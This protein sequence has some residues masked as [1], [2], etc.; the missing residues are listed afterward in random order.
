MSA[1]KLGMCL[2]IACAV[3]VSARMQAAE[4]AV[5][6]KTF[7]TP[8]E[9]V[10]ALVAAAEKFDVTALKE[11]AGPDG[12]DLVVTDDP[13]LDKNQ[14]TA[15]AAQARVKTKIVRDP[16]NP[17]IVTFIVGNEDWPAP[18]RW[19]KK[20]VDGSSIPRRGARKSCTAALEP[21]SS[22]P[23][24]SVAATSRRSSS[25]PPR[26]TTARS[27]TSTPSASSARRQTGR[28]GMES[29]GWNVAGAV[30]ED[31]AGT[32]PRGTRSG[33]TR[34]TATTSRS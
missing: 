23:S 18:T 19:F 6:Q 3:L 32:S 28:S 25:T 4:P 16:K 12:V 10:A 2:G 21:T 7:A 15:F 27:S 5:T 31:I 14:A 26:N 8:E 17:K 24:K 34:F 1:T 33:T 9:A 29:R 22:T 30:G 13:V 11:I 20:G